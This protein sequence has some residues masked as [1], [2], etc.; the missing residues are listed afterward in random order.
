M[1]TPCGSP[2]VLSSNFAGSSL[3]AE[4]DG[5]AHGQ[6]EGASLSSSLHLLRQEATL[7]FQRLLMVKDCAGA[8]H[9]AVSR[10]RFKTLI[11]GLLVI[12]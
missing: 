6:V 7:A 11:L 12:F 4:A 1:A 5:G 3:V 2:Y 9:R 10:C 8:F